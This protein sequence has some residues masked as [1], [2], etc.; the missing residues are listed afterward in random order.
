LKTF[1]IQTFHVSV[2]S[3]PRISQSH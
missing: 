3:Q 1:H 2:G